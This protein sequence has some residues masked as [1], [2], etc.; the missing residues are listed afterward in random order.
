MNEKAQRMQSGP[1]AQ[2]PGHNILVN[3]ETV[4]QIM[5]LRNHAD[6][7]AQG[8]QLLALQAIDGGSVDRDGS[9]TNGKK[10]ADC[11]EECSLA[12]AAGPENCNLLPSFYVEGNPFKHRSSSFRLSHY[13]IMDR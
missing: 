13:Y 1:A 11:A 10:S 3:L 5:A 7:L 4:Y 12:C 2:S 9:R 6:L 8:A